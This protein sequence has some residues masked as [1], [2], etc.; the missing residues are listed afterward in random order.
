M[1]DPL[2][3]LKCQDIICPPK[4]GQGPI[5]SALLNPAGCKI[6]IGRYQWNSLIIF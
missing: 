5:Q 3:M 1:S 4:L 6:E 2:S